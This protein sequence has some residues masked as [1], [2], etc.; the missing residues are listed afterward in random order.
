[1]VFC[2]TF[3][4]PASITDVFEF[5]RDFAL[6]ALVLGWAGVGATLLFKSRALALV[7]LALGFAVEIFMLNR[8]LR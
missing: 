3:S 8:V 6:V 5:L 2:M 1:M 7:W 4:N